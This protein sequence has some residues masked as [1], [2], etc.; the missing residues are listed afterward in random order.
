MSD[1]S[2]APDFTL[3]QKVR[4]NTLI[5]TF[6][7]GTEQRR[8][9]WGTSL[10]SWT[11]QYKNRTSSELSTIQTLFDTKLGSGTAFTW[12]NPLDSTEYTVR[13]VEDSL[14]AEL[15]AYGIYDFEFQLQQ[16]K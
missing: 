15:K 3:S 5:S 11:L 14:Q 16:V 9:K 7:N 8:S 2:L 12:T 10:R 13:F 4:Y 1:L 6:E